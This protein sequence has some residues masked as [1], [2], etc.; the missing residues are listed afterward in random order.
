MYCVYTDYCFCFYLLKLNFDEI[1]FLVCLVC[2]K[3]VI[4]FQMNVGYIC[5]YVKNRF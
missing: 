3:C 2:D 5:R 1:V 4:S